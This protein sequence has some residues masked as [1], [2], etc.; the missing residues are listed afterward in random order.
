MFDPNLSVPQETHEDQAS[1]GPDC[2]P[3]LEPGH[4]LMKNAPN[5]Y[6]Q[7]GVGLVIQQFIQYACLKAGIGL[8]LGVGLQSS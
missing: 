2:G 8:E 7:R 1:W 4:I 5:I 3:S 6:I